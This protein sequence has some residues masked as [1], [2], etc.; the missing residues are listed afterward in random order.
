MAEG[1]DVVALEGTPSRGLEKKAREGIVG[2]GA[3]SVEDRCSLLPA[4]R[5]QAVAGLVH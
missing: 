2:G 4:H 3:Q 5:P 1:L